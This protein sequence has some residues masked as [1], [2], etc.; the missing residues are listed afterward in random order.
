M[1]N[2]VDDRSEEIFIGCE[3]NSPAHIIRASYWDWGLDDSPE[4][5]LELQSDMPFGFFTRVR[6]AFNYV[7]FGTRLEWHDVIPKADDLRKLQVLISKYLERYEH[8]EAHC[9]VEREKKKES[10]ESI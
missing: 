4:F 2:K 3:C 1:Y 7:F 8:Y 10:N 5:Y 6:K 9:K